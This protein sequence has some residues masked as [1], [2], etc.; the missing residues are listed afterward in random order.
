M[1]T[2]FGKVLRI[3]RINTSENAG[4]MA[5][6]LHISKSYL[7]SIENGTR[8]IPIDIEQRLYES[9]DLTLK[10]KEKIQKAIIE[11]FSVLKIDMSQYSDKVKNIICEILNGNISESK[12]DEIYRILKN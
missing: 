4:E 3:I 2:E 11:S 12:A 6:K 5:K 7:S 8:N 10:D 1:L 9:Y